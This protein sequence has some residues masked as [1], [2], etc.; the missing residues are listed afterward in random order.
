MT[1]PRHEPTSVQIVVDAV[2]DMIRR[3]ELQ[4]GDHL[5]ESELRRRVDV[6][7]ST[8]REALGRLAEVGLVT[9]EPYRGA[10]VRRLHASEVADLYRVREALEGLAARMAAERVRDGEV[11]SG[12]LRRLVADMGGHRSGDDVLAYADVNNRFHQMV[13]AMSGSPTLA[14]LVAL[15]R[16]RVFR[17]QYEHLLGP[18]AKGDSIDGH[19]SVADAVVTGDPDRAESAMRAH[20]RLSRDQVMQVMPD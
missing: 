9:I 7:R 8:V 18:S 20:V 3:G 4:P 19:V 16:S 5:V 11:G 13:A 2:T 12:D 15:L 17:S 1:P 14:E 10:T 6:G